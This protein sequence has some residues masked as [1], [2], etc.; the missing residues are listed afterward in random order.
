MRN[1]SRRVPDFPPGNRT[2]F[3]HLRNLSP[4]SAF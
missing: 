4:Q 2:T 3:P 1:Q